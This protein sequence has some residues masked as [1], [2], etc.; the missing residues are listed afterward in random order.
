MATWELL[1]DLLLVALL[2]AVFWL[3]SVIYLQLTAKSQATPSGHQGLFVGDMCIRRRQGISIFALAVLF[4]AESAH[5]AG[6]EVAPKWLI[7]AW[8]FFSWF[9]CA[10]IPKGLNVRQL[11]APTFVSICIYWIGLFLYVGQINPTFDIFRD[12]TNPRH[13]IAD[14]VTQVFRRN[15]G[16][17]LKFVAGDDAFA[18]SASFYSKDH[19][20]SVADLDFVRTSWVN[21]SQVRHAGVVV[22]CEMSHPDCVK[23][24]VDHLG[25]AQTTTVWHGLD[26]DGD[27]VSVTELFYAP[28]EKGAGKRFQ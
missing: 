4:T 25:P 19:P 18:F 15:F 21:E 17:P 5:L 28:T 1:L 8:L 6:I 9:L 26:E 14:D 23:T 3:S 22:I 10:A 16:Q 7:P 24:T 20:V 2:P 11:I 12:A 27:T 13:A